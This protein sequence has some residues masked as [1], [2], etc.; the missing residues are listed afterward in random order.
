LGDLEAVFG[1]SDRCTREASVATD[2]LAAVRAA[3]RRCGCEIC[4]HDLEDSD[5]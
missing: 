1:A 4:V 5:E 2:D 3:R